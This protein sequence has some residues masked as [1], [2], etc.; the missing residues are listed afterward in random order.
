MGALAAGWHA[1]HDAQ[2]NRYLRRRHHH[3]SDRSTRREPEPPPALLPYPPDPTLPPPALL[4]SCRTAACVLRSQAVLLQRCD[5]EQPVDLPDGGGRRAATRHAHA[6]PARHAP[7]LAR[8]HRRDG[9]RVWWRGRHGGD[10]QPP[11][12]QQGCTATNPQPA[13][14]GADGRQ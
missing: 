6:P 12:Q 1:C 13:W 2:H 7:R 3:H 4:T 14:Q 8:H 9:Q 10:A 11:Q 5:A